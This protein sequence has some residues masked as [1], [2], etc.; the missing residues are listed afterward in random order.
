MMHVDMSNLPKHFDHNSATRELSE[1]WDNHGTYKFVPDGSEV[2]SIDTPPPTVSGS[3]HVGHILSYTHA[4]IVARYQRMNGKTVF[5]PM[6]WDDNGLPTERRVQNYYGITCD[7]DMTYDPDI[8]PSDN[9][10]TEQ[11]E[12]RPISRKNFIEHCRHLTGIDEKAFKNLWRSIGLSV[13]WREEYTTIDSRSMAASQYSFLDLFRKGHIYNGTAP[14]MWDTTFHCAIAQAETE[15]RLTAGA[16]HYIRIG[17]ADSEDVLTIATTRPELLPACVG[18]TAHP[19]DSRFQKLFGRT[20]ITPLFGVPV[21]VFPSLEADPEKGTGILMVCT[22]G[23]ATDVIWQQRNRLPVRQILDF[24]GK[25]TIPRFGS[26][27]F[28]S[29]HSGRANDCAVQLQGLFVNQARK[30]I[31]TL[32]EAEGVMKRDPEPIDHMV[33]YYEKGSRPLE[34]ISARQWFVRLLDK[35]SMLLEKAREVRWHP[36]YMLHRFVAWTEGLQYDWCIS[37]QRFFGVP[38]PVWLPLDESLEAIYDSPIFPQEEQLPTDPMVDTPP[39]YSETDRNRPGGFIGERD[40]LDTWFTSSLTPLIAS[41]WFGNKDDRPALPMDLRPQGHDIIRTW[42]FYTIAKA[43]LHCDSIPWRRIAVS[44]WVLDP[45]RKKLS[46]SVGNASTPDGSIERFSADGMRYWSATSRL[47]VDTAI[48]EGGMKT[49]LRLVTKIYNA[50]KFVLSL[51]GPETIDGLIISEPIDRSFLAALSLI[52]S[53]ARADMEQFEYT[54]ALEAIESF[55]WRGFTDTYI[56]LVKSRAK[57]EN[58]DLARSASAILSLRLG[59]DILL[60]LFAPFLPFVTE[61]VW[62]WDFASLRQEPS[63]HRA[64]WPTLSDFDDYDLTD[65]AAFQLASECLGLIH[66]AK[67][68]SGKS[69]GAAVISLELSRPEEKTALLETVRKDLMA[70]GRISNLEI[71]T[72]K[73]DVNSLAFEKM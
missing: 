17:M 59:L 42:A 51:H 22:F 30:K 19:D 67:T 15:E 49:G 25:V 1:F 72:G 58:V 26:G 16:Y 6:G 71:S 44:G 33:K 68:T 11:Q 32:L 18:I 65:D 31:A 23:D 69:V 27:D 54:R 37:R 52:V 4:D 64:G 36:E 9:A 8:K 70:A 45:N 73:L 14:V 12:P 47:G 24:N 41:G 13:D 55:F 3:L 21:P 10:G 66:K 39:G 57:G 46:K 50:S 53:T 60:R 35:K 38:I 28:P 62:Q 61:H 7:P 5:Y 34:L 40:I 20:A 48:D 63:I 56:E 2:F 29:R 43:A